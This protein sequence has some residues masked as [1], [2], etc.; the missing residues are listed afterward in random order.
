MTSTDIG[1]DRVLMVCIRLRTSHLAGVDES[2]MLQQGQMHLGIRK[3]QQLQAKIEMAM[4]SIRHKKMEITNTA[5]ML[6]I[7]NVLIGNKGVVVIIRRFFSCNMIYIN[8]LHLQNNYTFQLSDAVQL[9]KLF[10]WLG[11]VTFIIRTT[12]YCSHSYRPIN[13][14]KWLSQLICMG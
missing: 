13:E 9:S 1:F 6:C 7:V 5:S 4:V 14:C 3:Q 2:V 10:K 11:C 12:A 8:E